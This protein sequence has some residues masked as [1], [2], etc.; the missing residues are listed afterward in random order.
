[1]SENKFKK[2]LGLFQVI[3]M[4][5][6]GMIAAWMVEIKLWFELSGVGSSVAL[7]TCAILVLSL[8]LIY[9]ELTGMLPYAGGANIWI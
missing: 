1:M 9:A 8:C 2:E 6:G 4:A 5:A 3:A 7:I